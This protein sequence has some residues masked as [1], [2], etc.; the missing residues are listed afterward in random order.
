MVVKEGWEGESFLPGIFV[1]ESVN[2]AGRASLH[3]SAQ[4][5]KAWAS[6][7]RHDLKDEPCWVG[8]Y[9]RNC[10]KRLAIQQSTRKLKACHEFIYKSL[11]FL[12]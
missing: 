1:L 3:G 6:P 12:I 9:L 10:R 11:I 8:A 4:H 5:E 7:A 2:W